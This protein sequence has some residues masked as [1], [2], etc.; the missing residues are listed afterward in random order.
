MKH[1]SKTALVG[2]AAFVFLLIANLWWGSRVRIP[3]GLVAL[4]FGEGS[5]ARDE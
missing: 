4:S 1:T 2:L 5:P 3:A